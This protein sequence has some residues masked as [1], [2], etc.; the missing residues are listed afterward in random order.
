[1]EFSNV[2]EESVAGR[3]N[4]GRA[5]SEAVPG[6]GSILY[7]LEPLCG[8]DIRQ[9]RL[10]PDGKSIICKKQRSAKWIPKGGYCRASV[11]SLQCSHNACAPQG[12]TLPRRTRSITEVLIYITTS[13]HDMNRFGNGRCTLTFH[14]QTQRPHSRWRLRLCDAWPCRS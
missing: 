4:A 9:S 2:G 10:L 7:H 13:W 6:S 14:N 8:R 1:M 11:C 3:E 12:Q 5:C